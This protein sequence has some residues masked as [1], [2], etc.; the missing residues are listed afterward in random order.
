VLMERVWS[1]VNDAFENVFCHLPAGFC[2]KS[3]DVNGLPVAL[4]IVHILM[5]K[6]TLGNWI[7]NLAIGK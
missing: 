5:C 1:C 7:V 3:G 2:T 4:I 6:P